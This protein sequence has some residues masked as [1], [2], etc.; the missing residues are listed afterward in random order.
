[1]GLLPRRAGGAAGRQ[2]LLHGI[3]TGS[4]GH[5]LVALGE[6]LQDALGVGAPT[7]VQAA[8]RRL[9][10]LHIPPRYPDAHPSGTPGSHY[11]AEDS[12]QALDD[13]ARVL[14]YVDAAWQQL[15]EG[16]AGGD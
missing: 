7:E 14:A 4:R 16:A 10:R 3:G 12:D 15:R 9:S 8:L 1:M 2:A 5:D 11:G 13:A 6:H